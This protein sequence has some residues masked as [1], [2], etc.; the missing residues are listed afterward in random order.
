MS[1]LVSGIGYLFKKNKVRF[2]YKT[3]YKKTLLIHSLC[4]YLCVC[5]SCPM[6][7]TAPSLSPIFLLP[8]TSFSLSLLL[9]SSLPLLL[10]LPSSL[11]LPPLSL[12][13][14]S[15]PLSP[16][17]LPLPPLSLPR[18]VNHVQGLGTIS[19]PNEVT[20]T[21]EDGS[22]EVLKTKNILIA[23]GSEVTPFPG[24]EVE[25]LCA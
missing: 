14:L 13:P 1:G 24:I 6:P 7:A 20:V 22:K 25:I 15:L 4:V 19:G 8:P 12:P 18:Q 11:P 16:L 17:S 21:K 10:P 3:S 2:V 9:S 23:T 5:P